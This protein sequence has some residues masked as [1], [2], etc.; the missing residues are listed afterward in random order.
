VLASP[1]QHQD[2]RDEDLRL[3]KIAAIEANVDA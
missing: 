2:S 1:Q 3:L